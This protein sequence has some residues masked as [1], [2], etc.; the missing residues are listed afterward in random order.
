MGAAVI[1][2]MDASPVLEFSEHV[3][4]LVAAPVE[5]PVEGRR[6]FPVGF[7]RY[8]G[9]DAAR[10]ERLAELDLSRKSAGYLSHLHC[11]RF[12][13]ERAFPA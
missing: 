1:A 6:V 12:K 4:D 3:L 2:G 13:R 10:N 7:W 9:G 8:A 5:H 11:H